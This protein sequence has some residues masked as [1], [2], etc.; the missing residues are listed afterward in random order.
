MTKI[1][2]NFPFSRAKFPIYSFPIVHDCSP[3]I[4][5]GFTVCLTCQT[6]QVVIN[7]EDVND[8]H[9][10]FVRDEYLFSVLDSTPIGFHLIFRQHSNKFISF[11]SFTRL[12][13][14]SFLIMI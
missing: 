11:D 1:L 7:V 3:L 5:R 2:G 13:I 6:L 10:N 4:P 14:V 12:I 8:E 9:P